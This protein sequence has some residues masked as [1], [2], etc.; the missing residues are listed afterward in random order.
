MTLPERL[1]EIHRGLAR[2]R[3]PHAFGGAI[4]LAYWTLDPRGTNDID[5]NLFVGPDRSSRAV[6]AL[7]DGVS[8]PRSLAETVA[9]EGQIRLWWDE[10]PVDLFFDYAPVHADAARNKRVVP[11]AGTKIPILGPV[12]LA[13]FKVMFDRTRDWADLEAMVAA[14]TLDVEAVH[15]ALGAMIAVDDPRLKRL[16]EISS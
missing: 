13:V 8:R 2:R 6:G 11:F 9:R 7:P 10:T 3:I 5:L 15:K 12:E 1:V 14:G 16:D 4:A